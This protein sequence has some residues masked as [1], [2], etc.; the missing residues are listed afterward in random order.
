MVKTTIFLWFFFTPSQLQKHSFGGF[1]DM[2]RH[3][4]KLN[5]ANSY[6]PTCHRCFGTSH[7]LKNLGA[8]QNVWK[9]T[10][11][12]GWPFW[13]PHLSRYHFFMAILW[14]R[15]CCV[16]R[17]IP[18]HAE[19]QRIVQPGRAGPPPGGLKTMGFWWDFDMLIGH[20]WPWLADLAGFGD[21]RNHRFKMPELGGVREGGSREKSLCW[22]QAC[23]ACPPLEARVTPATASFREIRGTISDCHSHKWCI[24]W[25]VFSKIYPS[26][27]I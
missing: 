27:P 18:H 14:T 5:Q 23:Q 6:M 24:V 22:T 26:K 16:R 17:K 11:T 4:S 7:V 1:P 10:P 3:G 12:L 13:D 2:G 20:D 9:K 21:L 25:C 19:R 8:T 15:H